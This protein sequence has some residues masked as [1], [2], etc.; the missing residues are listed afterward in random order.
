MQSVWAFRFYPSRK[1]LIN[2][3]FVYF[4]RI[5]TQTH[6]KLTDQSLINAWE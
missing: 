2:E 1:Q 6:R 5:H 4:C 3:V